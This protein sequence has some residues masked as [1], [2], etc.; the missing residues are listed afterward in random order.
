MALYHEWDF[1]AAEVQFRRAVALDERCLPARQFYFN[2]LT[3][4]GRFG[5]ALAE[6]DRTLELDP[7]WVH[8][9]AAR[10]WILYF[11]R[12]PD[13]A[14]RELDR[15]LAMEPGHALAHLWRGWALE[16]AGRLAEAL[17][18]LEKAADLSGRSAEAVGGLGRALAATGRTDEARALLAELERMRR[19][20]YVPASLPAVVHLT[21]GDRAA[22]LAELERALAERDKSLALLGVEPKLDPLRGDPAFAALIAGI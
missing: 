1:A 8:L 19:E 10:G 17:A 15:A 21:L 13:E 20:R 18:A 9:H 6:S 5:E 7:L 11:A 16:Q 14:L 22:A 12:R 4:A 3:A 2:L